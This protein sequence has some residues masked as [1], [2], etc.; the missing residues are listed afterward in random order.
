[1]D[2]IADDALI[3]SFFDEAA[4]F[5]DPPTTPNRSDE[6]DNNALVDSYVADALQ[7]FHEEDL[8]STA[9]PHLPPPYMI[10]ESAFLS[11][12]PELSMLH[13]EKWHV[14]V[15]S[16]EYLAS[17]IRATRAAPAEEQLYGI[18]ASFQHLK[19][20]EPLLRTD[21]ANDMTKIVKRN[22]VELHTE[23]VAPFNIDDAQDEGIA[24]G[25][26]NLDLPA[27][28]N[29]ELKN[30]K[31]AIDQ[32]TAGFM[33]HVFSTLEAD[34]Q[35]W[36]AEGR[37]RRVLRKLSSPLL[38]LSPPLS[39]ESLP[40]PIAEV[41]LTSTPE[42]P[43]AA[44]A[45]FL[46][47]ELAEQDMLD[48]EDAMATDSTDSTDFLDATTTGA[49]SPL[50][51]KAKRLQDLKVSDPLLPETSSEPPSKKA[52]TVSFTKELHTLIPRLP[53]EVSAGEPSTDEA[54]ATMTALLAP[55]AQPGVDNLEQEQL[56]EID[57]T[58]RIDVPTVEDISLAAPWEVYA[59]RQRDL[60]IDVFNK[61]VKTNG[62]WSGASKM[63]KTLPWSP[64]PSYLA[65]IKPEGDFDDGSCRRYLEKVKFD[66]EVDFANLTWKPDGLLVLEEDDD[67]Q[68][69]ELEACDFP[70]DDV[71][72]SDALQ[73]SGQA[74]Q[75]R[76]A[77]NQHAVCAGQGASRTHLE[78][79]DA[80]K[81]SLS[82]VSSFF[83]QLGRGGQR[84]GDGAP[85]EPREVQNALPS[86]EELIRR[87]AAQLETSK[88]KHDHL[89]A[90][91]QNAKEA[92]KDANSL[93][94]Q[95]K[96]L[97][98]QRQGLDQFLA[99]QNQQAIDQST[100]LRENDDNVNS[101]EVIEHPQPSAPPPRTKPLEQRQSAMPTPA[102]N[103]KQISTTIITSPSFD[104]RLAARLMSYCPNIHEIIR[105]PIPHLNLTEAHLTLSPQTGLHIT[106][107]QQLIQKPL[108]GREN[109]DQ[110]TFLSTIQ[111]I[112]LKYSTLILLINNGHGQAIHHNVAALNLFTSTLN[113]PTNCEVRTIFIASEDEKEGDETHL[114]KWIAT[115]IAK[116][117]SPAI[118]I[119]DD[120]TYWERFLRIAGFNAFAAQAILDALKPGDLASFV[121]MSEEE[122]VHR[123]GALLGGETVLRRASKVID[124]KWASMATAQ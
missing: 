30:E 99:L 62:K 80:V 106:N 8:M 52:K 77:R 17:V 83:S 36:L 124:A 60:M 104:R 101:I 50:Q 117:S 4:Y 85:C 121:L 82:H 75:S 122:R 69:E 114:I 115:C 87:R 40:T 48:A 10:D 23:H 73:I 2:E 72:L 38:P 22:A 97:I 110:P 58:L 42:D 19:I 5:Y 41:E 88:R 103:P 113:L 66:G 9:Y 68:D 29:D 39:P 27:H 35:E 47:A 95:P 18:G 46:D 67:D 86:I 64:F 84:A 54:M 94:Q 1:M 90:I 63:E 59:G 96:R 49:S 102:I 21:P 15:E 81:G 107:L 89:V 100:S 56:V 65:K 24:W 32:E 123:F 92:T 109:E 7:S 116:Y 37:K 93:S 28:V 74:A 16:V 119:L 43:S 108:P 98:Q 14:D 76:A 33:K 105:H 6:I 20:E 78:L 70:G 57:T 53:S 120:E 44:E 91:A 31:W 11:N 51:R 26:S 12:N 25:A 13:H 112:S 61:I 79:D 118:K 3:K 45:A 71:D 111:K 55:L 34:L